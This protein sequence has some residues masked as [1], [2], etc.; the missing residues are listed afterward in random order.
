[1]AIK[2]CPI[3][4]RRIFDYDNQGY[5]S[6]GIISIKCLHCGNVVKIKLK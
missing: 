2:K 6:N 5:I 4:K 1:M 3:C